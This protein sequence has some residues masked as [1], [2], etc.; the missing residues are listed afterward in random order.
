[1]AEDYEKA[2]ECYTKAIDLNSEN[3]IYFA[4][5]AAAFTRKTKQGPATNKQ[6]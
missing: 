5:R 1:M 6:T 4:N 2:V 3:A